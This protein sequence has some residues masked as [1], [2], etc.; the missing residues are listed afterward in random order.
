MNS[1]ASLMR[2]IRRAPTVSQSIHAL[3]QK[4]TGIIN[5]QEGQILIFNNE[6]INTKTLNQRKLSISK[7][8]VGS[9]FIDVLSLYGQ[10]VANPAFDKVAEGKSV[11]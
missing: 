11:I 4:I 10:E 7:T 1:L 3:L 8:I 5:C 9:K 2:D 6:F